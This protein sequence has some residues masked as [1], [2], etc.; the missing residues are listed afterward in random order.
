MR[1]YDD[2]AKTGM[3]KTLWSSHI[4]PEVRRGGRTAKEVPKS[5]DSVQSLTSDSEGFDADGA[6]AVRESC[7]EI[8]ACVI[9]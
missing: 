8:N 4:I 2:A 1:A 3:S 6:V 9:L 7:S 5:E